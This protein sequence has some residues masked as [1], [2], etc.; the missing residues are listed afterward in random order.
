ME[1]HFRDWVA[2]LRFS[3]AFLW[4][5]FRSQDV[6]PVR[7]E[8]VC[9]LPTSRL[10]TTWQSPLRTDV[11]NNLKIIFRVILHKRS[12]NELDGFMP[13]DN[14][15]VNCVLICILLA[16]AGYLSS[17]FK[18]LLNFFLFRFSWSLSGFR[19]LFNSD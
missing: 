14:F 8:A 5:C 11:F 7:K 12:W 6:R 17:L 9:C 2:Q 13:A 10:S 15:M 18:N 1:Y 19:N 4:R 3:G 16:F